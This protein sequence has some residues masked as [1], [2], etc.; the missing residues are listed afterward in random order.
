MKI[1]LLIKILINFISVFNLA[2]YC[3]DNSINNFRHKKSLKYLE[4]R[5]ARS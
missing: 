3:H 5:Q 2:I 4:L 1:E